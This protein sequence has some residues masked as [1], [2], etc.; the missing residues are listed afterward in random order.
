MKTRGK[1][2]GKS[3]IFAYAQ[4]T[5]RANGKS[6]RGDGDGD[7]VR[8]GDGRWR[9]DSCDDE[10]IQVCVECVCGCEHASV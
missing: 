10:I 9:S 6:R 5:H 1:S 8:H 2:L 3:Q 7:Y 4:E